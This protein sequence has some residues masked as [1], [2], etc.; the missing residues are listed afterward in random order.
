LLPEHFLQEQQELAAHQAQE[1]Q[2]LDDDCGD[3]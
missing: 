2:E 1:N 3:G